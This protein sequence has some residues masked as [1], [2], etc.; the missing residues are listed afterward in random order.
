MCQISDE[1]M[2]LHSVQRKV[3]KRGSGMTDRRMD[4]QP[5]GKLIVPLDSKAGRGLN[6]KKKK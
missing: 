3:Q 6:K 2:H 5:E 1:Y 4:R